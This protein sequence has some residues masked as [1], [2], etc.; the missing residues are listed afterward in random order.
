MVSI[1]VAM[2]TYYKI[3]YKDDP[4]KYIKGTPAYQSYDKTG[5]IF[6]SLGQLRT[7]L[8]GV[9]NQ[10]DWDVKHGGNSR[11]RVANWEVVELEMVVKEVKGVHE[12]ITAKKLKEL[13]LK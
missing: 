13:L 12:V 8:T 1:E 9:M 4:E 2:T 6:Q 11:N 5:R 7:F 10:D 3:R